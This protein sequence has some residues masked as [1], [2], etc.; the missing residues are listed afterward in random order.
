[1][2]LEQPNLNLPPASPP[3]RSAA[4]DQFGP[5]FSH[6]YKGVNDDNPPTFLGME[7]LVRYASLACTQHLR[8]RL[9]Q[10]R[11]GGAGSFPPH[12]PFPSFTLLPA[13]STHV[14]ADLQAPARA[15][16]CLW[17]I[18]RQQDNSSHCL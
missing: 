17:P 12:R 4:L 6:L 9:E 15:A 11:V 14:G 7:G 16:D 10:L 1:M 3:S 2:A 8:G 18:C 5:R 13:R